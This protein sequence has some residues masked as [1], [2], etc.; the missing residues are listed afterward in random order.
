MATKPRH[1][2]LFVFFLF[3]SELAFYQHYMYMKNPDQLSHNV[4]TAQKSW[5]E[6]PRNADLVCFII[7]EERRGLWKRSV[8]IPLYTNITNPTFTVNE[9]NCLYCQPLQSMKYIK[10]NT[11]RCFQ[12]QPT[13]C[14]QG[15]A[16]AHT[17]THAQLTHKQIWKIDN[18]IWDLHYIMA[19]Y[20]LLSQ[21]NV[22]VQQL[23]SSHDII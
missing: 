8:T 4:L 6:F 22:V 20:Q 11:S 10:H 14:F 9:I 7:N 13:L 23:T 1:E 15:H 2:C 16:R 5:L 21:F 18:K 12:S 19:G 3:C 17:Y